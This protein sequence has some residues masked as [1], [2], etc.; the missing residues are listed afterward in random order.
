MVTIS[1]QQEETK[2]TDRWHERQSGKN[3]DII[4]PT[5]RKRRV[6]EGSAEGLISELEISASVSD[7]QASFVDLQE[8]HPRQNKKKGIGFYYARMVSCSHVFPKLHQPTD[9]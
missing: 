5:Q 3:K 2:E 7:H 6:Q 8:V 1:I 4:R 9:R